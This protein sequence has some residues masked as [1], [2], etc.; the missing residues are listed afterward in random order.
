M[1]MNPKRRPFIVR[2]FHTK[3]N[4]KFIYFCA[5]FW[6]EIKLQNP[7]ST[8]IAKPFW[9]CFIML[10]MKMAMP[11]KSVETW[12]LTM[13]FFIYPLPQI[14]Y[15]REKNNNG[16]HHSV[17][18]LF[19]V[20]F[21]LFARVQNGLRINFCFTGCLECLQSS[22]ITAAAKQTETHKLY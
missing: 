22:S 18:I 7:K 11:F 13:T 4:S 19:S 2:C 14:I 1:V 17:E 6:I 3:I 5:C 8:K 15:F 10:T 20:S 16:L 9:L 12:E 21:R